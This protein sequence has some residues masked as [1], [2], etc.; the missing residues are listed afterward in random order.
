MWLVVTQEG[1]HYLGRFS[2]QNTAAR[3]CDVANLKVHGASA[4]TNFP[5]RY[6]HMPAA[7]SSNTI[8]SGCVLMSMF[9]MMTLMLLAA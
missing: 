6:V 9:N 3:A 4:A 8:S 1:E 5:A 7:E 2:Q